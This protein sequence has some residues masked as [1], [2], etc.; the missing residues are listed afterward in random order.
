MQPL[1]RDGVRTPFRSLE[2]EAMPTQWSKPKPVLGADVNLMKVS[3]VIISGNV[4]VRNIL[5]DTF[6]HLF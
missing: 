4:P 5:C 2:N 6:Y 3:E 1:G